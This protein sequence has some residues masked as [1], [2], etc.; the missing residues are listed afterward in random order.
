VLAALFFLLAVLGLTFAIVVLRADP[1]RWDNQLFAA[2]AALDG[3]TSAYRGLVLAGDRAFEELTV[4]NNCARSAFV[5]VWLSIEFAYSFPF[6]R[7]APVRLRVPTLLAVGATVALSAVPATRVFVLDYS[8]FFLFIPAFVL[9]LALVARNLRQAGGDRTGILVVMGA[10]VFRWAIPVLTWGIV[11]FVWPDAFS[12]FIFFDATAAVLVS[13]VAFTAAILRG[14][15]FSVRGVVAEIV[16][17]VSAAVAVVVLTALAVDGSLRAGGGPTELR[18]WL[19]LAALVP[20]AAV[21]LAVAVRGRIRGPMLQALDP[22]RV[23][24]EAAVTRAVDTRD[25][26]PEAMLARVVDAIA[27]ITGQPGAVDVRYLRARGPLVAA[28]LP[29]ALADYLATARAPWVHRTLTPDLPA[30]LR[31]A[32]DADVLVPVRSGVALFG[33]L[34]IT[35]GRLDRDTLVAAGTL[36]D[37]LA[38]KLENFELFAE[39]ET[40]RRLA[41]LGAFAA[42]IAHDIRTPLT[43]V[44]MNVQ[45]LRGKVKLPEGDMEHF[46]IAL[47]ELDR[48]SASIGE[49]LEYAKPI[50][51][52]RASVDLRDVVEDASRAVQPQLS[53]RGLTLEQRHDAG[54]PAVV[55]DAQ[56]LRQVVVNLLENAANASQPGR[57][58]TIATR[59]DGEGAVAIDVIDQG[60]GIEGADLEHIFE[61]FFTKRADGTGLGLAICQKVVSAHAGEIRVRSS[62][63]AGSTFTV[64]LPREASAGHESLP[65]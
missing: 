4:Q 36:A 62:P 40:S 27:E 55:G 54:R 14:Q 37:R 3:T 52:Q 59:A 17:Y 19:V 16:G 22:E 58:I 50:P 44:K 1:R 48:L 57:A 21:T 9:L 20:L 34:A 5:L 63:G 31:G 45:I 10:L 43:S 33:A 30:A 39:L 64:L 47:E 32:L 26:A 28:A 12:A 41:T 13:Y 8:E 65:A 35:G 49:L 56:R 38:L 25:P 6:S 46:A 42:A 23:K 2:M 29:R 60:S 18:V 7:P 53:G 24:R 61:P 11:R 15:L 51:V